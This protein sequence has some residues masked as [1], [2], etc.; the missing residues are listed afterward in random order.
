MSI[1]PITKAQA[2]KI[3]KAIGY[4]FVATFIATLLVAPELS[5][6]ALNGALVAAVNAALVTVKQ[7]FTQG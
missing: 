7:L 3:A 6:A 5:K 4:S 1:S 2:I